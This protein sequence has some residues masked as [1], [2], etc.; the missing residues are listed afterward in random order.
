[1]QTESLAAY[2][3]CV[4]DWAQWNIIV[5]VKRRLLH[6]LWRDLHV[7]MG[8]LCFSGSSHHLF[9]DLE[10]QMVV[11]RINVFADQMR[12]TR[13]TA[14]NFRVIESHHSTL[15]PRYLQFPT[16]QKPSKSLVCFYCVRKRCFLRFA[17]MRK[18]DHKAATSKPWRH[19]RA[20]KIVGVLPGLQPKIVQMENLWLPVLLDFGNDEVINIFQ[21]LSTVKPYILQ[22]S[23]FTD[24]VGLC[25]G[26]GEVWE[27]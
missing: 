11:D 17:H 18:K 22:A 15:N 7:S 3:Q 21:S 10:R 20:S 23:V 14:A 4:Y 2:V 1:M 19:L 12:T 9:S 26:V 25:N 8:S 13:F 5:K 27:L 24:R 6:L 16:T